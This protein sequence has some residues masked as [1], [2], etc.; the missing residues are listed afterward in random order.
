MRTRA[1]VAAAV[2][3]V[4]IVLAGRSVSPASAG[5][6]P[7]RTCVYV[8]R[9]R[10][11]EAVVVD[12]LRVNEAIF[13]EIGLQHVWVHGPAGSVQLGFELIRQIEILEWRGKDPSRDEWTRYS[14]KVTGTTES[15]AYY[16][17]MDVRVM[18]GLAGKTPWYFF[19]A[20]RRDRGSNLWRI[21]FGQEC[22]G[23]TIPLEDVQPPAPP[24]PMTVI[25]ATLVEPLPLPPVGEPNPSELNDVF[26]PYNKWDLTQTSRATLGRNAEWMK[27]FPT[28]RILIEGQ[29]DPRGSNAYNLPLGLRRANASREYLVSL[30]IA[31]ERLETAAVAKTNLDCTEKTEDCWQRQRRVH[32]VLLSK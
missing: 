17:T 21:T 28:T 12:D 9:T 7:Y 31:A 19:P 10:P 1:G 29:A 26:F 23:P 18:R 24:L 27:R 22:V 11:T 5:A 15:I 14:V 2:S 30:G 8:D 13:D 16:G 6:K 25:T 20:T 4:A 3:V 32:F